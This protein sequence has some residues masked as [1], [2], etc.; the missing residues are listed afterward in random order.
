MKIRL[1]KSERYRGYQI[2]IDADDETLTIEN[3]EGKPVIH[4]VLEDFLDRLG[5]T[6]HEFKRQ[7]PRIDL[8]ARVKYQDAEGN[9]CDAIASSIGGGGLFIEQ[10]SPKPAGTPMRL[11]IDLPASSKLISAEGKVVWVR[12][13]IVDKILYP[14][15]G[16]QFTSISDQDRTEILRFIKQFHQQKEDHDLRPERSPR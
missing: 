7:Y 4:M 10:F 12:K 6:A 14:G 11:E 1:K 3:A 5:T 8:G 15:M 13:N 16:L 9:P 2:G